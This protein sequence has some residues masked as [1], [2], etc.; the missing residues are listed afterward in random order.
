MARDYFL[1]LVKSL[2]VNLFK[3]AMW[4]IKQNIKTVFFIGLLFFTLIT[5]AQ[6]PRKFYTRIGGDGYDY[7]Y[8][9]KQTLDNGYIIT[10]STSS[11]GQ[12]STDVY[13]MK[14]DSMGQIKF[15]RALG[16]AGN[17]VG[18]SVVQLADSSFVVAGYTNSIGVGGYDIYLIKTD[19]DGNEIWHKTFGG[20]DWDFAYSLQATADGGFIIGGTTYSIGHGAADGYVLKTD[21]NGNE[22]WHK[23]YGGVNDDEFKSVIQTSD[24]NYALTGYTKSYNDVNY[25]DGWIFRINLNGDSIY[26]QSVGGNYEDR[27]NNLIQFPNGNLYLVG[28]NMSQ[29]NGNNQVNWQYLT[30]IN[31]NLIASNFIGNT[32]TERYNASCVGLNGTVVTVG[33]NNYLGSSSDANIHLYTLNLGYVAYYPFGIENTDELFSVYPTRDK[34]FAAVGTCIGS[35]SK[36]NDILF[37]KTDSIGNYGMNITGINEFINDV[38]CITYPNPAND[39]LHIVLKT[40]S[41]AESFVY[42]LY[43]VEGHLV[44]SEKIETDN[45]ILDIRNLDLGLYIIQIHSDSKQLIYSSKISIVK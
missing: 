33:Y 38:E 8:D 25:G 30:D 43:D 1:A 31:N 10:G 41:R 42:S 34:G 7:G 4:L 11:F 5:V 2:N 27:F 23:T 15:Q 12:G 44:K 26:S 24:G 6:A 29:T 17:E 28:Y 20:P 40:K 21:A 32:N 3:N 39:Y 22:L 35:T 45:N 18:R 37:V 19:K 14:L 36:L 13:L 16:N 9:V